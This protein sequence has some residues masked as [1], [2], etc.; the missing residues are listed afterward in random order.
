VIFTWRLLADALQP[1]FGL[2]SA[3]WI[4]IF[5]II[6]G[7]YRLITRKRRQSTLRPEDERLILIHRKRI[8]REFLKAPDSFSV[9]NTLLP[10][11]EKARTG[12]MN[13]RKLKRRAIT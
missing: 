10:A 3:I 9:N 7:A 6:L 13:L 4:F 5:L 12:G 8:F 2:G 1:K 11:M